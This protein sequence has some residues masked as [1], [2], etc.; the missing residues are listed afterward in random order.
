MSLFSSADI[1]KI[2]KTA[3]QSTKLLDQ[4]VKST[5][6]N[7][8]ITSQLEVIYA[9][10]TKYFSDSE[11]ILIKDEQQLDEYVDKAIDQVY[12]GIDTETTGL[13][14]QK[15]KIVGMSL[16]FMNGTECYIPNKHIVP[17]FDEPYSGQL[18]YSQC[19]K[20]LEKMKAGGVKF[21]FANADFD[22]SMIY[23]DYGVDLLPNFYAD[24][25]LAWRCLK[26]DELDN[27]LKSL[28]HKYVQKGK[29]DPM[30]FSDFFLLKSFHI[31]N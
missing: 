16:Y 12:V 6:S 25:I 29:G 2:N 10:L 13:D 15:D 20:A 9:N 18:T 28:Y 22:L 14:R 27:R 31:V 5:R 3:K 7:K 23:K 26:E 4:T 1:A 24:V 8:S 11:A 30:Q 19:A 21:I 17:I